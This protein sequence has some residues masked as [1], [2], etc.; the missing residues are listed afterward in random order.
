MKDYK[1]YQHFTVSSEQMFI[2]YHRHFKP[3]FLPLTYGWA[4]TICVFILELLFARFELKITIF[5]R[6]CKLGFKSNDSKIGEFECI[7]EPLEDTSELGLQLFQPII[8][9][10]PST[11]LHSLGGF[12]EIVVEAD[13]HEVNEPLES[14]TL[15]SFEGNEDIVPMKVFPG[16]ALI[17]QKDTKFDES[18]RFDELLEDTLDIVYSPDTPLHS[19]GGFEQVVIKVDVHEIKEVLESTSLDSFE[20]FEDVVR[21]DSRGVTVINSDYDLELEGSK[22]DTIETD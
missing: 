10:R 13:V 22:I 11:P 6:N 7:D 16:L 15:N 9:H 2:T 21:V 20:G 3:M 18:D 12:E 4:V 19:F 1:N 17:T 8:V 14:I 5:W